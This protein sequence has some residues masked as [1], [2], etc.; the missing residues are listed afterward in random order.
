[1][2]YMSLCGAWKCT[3]IHTLREENYCADFLAKMGADSDDI[4]T[5][6]HHPP[7]GMAMLLVAD[8]SGVLFTRE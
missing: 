3:L 4:L 2:L 1:M 6:F 5:V 7:P 8:A